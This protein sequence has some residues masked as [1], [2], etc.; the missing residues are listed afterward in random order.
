MDRNVQLANTPVLMLST[1]YE[2]LFQTN[3]KRALSAILGGRAE[4]IEIH[5]HLTIGTSSGPVPF[6]IKVRF[7][8]GIILAN[9]KRVNVHAPLSRKNLFL[10]D[11]GKCQYCGMQISM[12]TATI[13]HIVPRS[14]GGVHVWENVVIA[15]I[16]C[17]QKKGSRLVS[18]TSMS[19]IKKPKVPTVSE[20]VYRQIN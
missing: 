1:G 5:D 4:V 18:N 2:P 17:N 20:I 11:S 14:K 7:V 19:L 13:D 12:K 6:P 9:I 16:P 3:W 15:C 8:T 10:R